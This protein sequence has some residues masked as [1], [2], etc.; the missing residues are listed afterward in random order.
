MH[1]E[2][3]HSVGRI[4]R[5]LFLVLGVLALGILAA[6]GDA[7]R[8][9]AQAVASRAPDVPY[10]PTPHNVVAQMLRLA[11]V[12]EG[13]VVYDLGCGDGRIVIAA[14]REHHA[15]GV[16]VD[17]DPQ[18]IRESRVNAVAAG[19][20]ERIRFIEQDLF[21]TEI[22]EATVVMLFLWPDVNLKLRPKLWRELRPGTRVI[23]YVH[24]MGDWTPQQTMTV[25]G[26]YGERRLYL[27]TIGSPQGR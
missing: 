1:F 9:F 5:W 6:G 22:R 7:G 12:R 16:C 15:R 27:W 10:D 11:Q 13:D 8:A 14:V 24:N 20:M 26:S 18:R 21:A 4:G 2:N 17:I 19:V 25:Q 3:R 23:S